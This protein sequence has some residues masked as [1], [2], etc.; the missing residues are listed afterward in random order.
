[1]PA[2][3]SPDHPTRNST[4]MQ[5]LS[6][7][8]ICILYCTIIFYIY[9]Y[10]CVHLYTCVHLCAFSHKDGNAISYFVVTFAALQQ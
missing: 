10:K 2:Q 3:M 1:M 9:L 8:P 7:P 4:P 6:Q 5:K